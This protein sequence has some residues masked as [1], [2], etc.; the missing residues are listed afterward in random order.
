MTPV[1]V[2]LP[3]TF[4]H[5]EGGS[6]ETHRVVVLG[7]IP[8]DVALQAP[9]SQRTKVRRH[10]IAKFFSLALESL[11]DGMSTPGLPWKDG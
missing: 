7:Y 8:L 6:S 10:L 2:A 1:C 9:D 4:K 5:L 3:D 11:E